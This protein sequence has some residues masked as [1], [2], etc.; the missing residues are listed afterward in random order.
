MTITFYTRN[1]L[2][3]PQYFIQAIDGVNKMS[4]F[5]D[6]PFT[7]DNR[8]AIAQAVVIAVQNAVD[9]GAEFERMDLQSLVSER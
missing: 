7:A 1:T 4:R 2:H 8:E 9:A 6:I 3:G 5:I